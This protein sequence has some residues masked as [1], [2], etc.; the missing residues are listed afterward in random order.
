VCVGV[1]R[2]CRAR[3]QP[4]TSCC[5][6]TCVTACLRAGSHDA[7]PTPPPLH[8]HLPPPPPRARVCRAVAR[9]PAAS[10]AGA[11]G[12][13]VP[14]ALCVCVC[15][16]V[17]ACVSASACVCKCVR[18]RALSRNRCAPDAVPKWRTHPCH[19][20]THHSTP[21]HAGVAQGD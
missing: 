21:L 18:A 9:Q 8:T 1:H 12:R 7:A 17:C 10:W 4:H 13:S 16:C 20:H 19:T 6:G 2:A 3:Q 5:V 11:Q 15:V 14:G